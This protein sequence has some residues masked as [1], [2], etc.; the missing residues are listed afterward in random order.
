MANKRVILIIL[1]GW[2][3]AP[4]W[5]GNAVES[6]ETPVM[7]NLWRKFPHTI[8]KAAEEAVGLPI[9]EPGNSEVGHLN[10]GCGQVV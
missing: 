3:Y 7:D 10:I 5:G 8:L 1:D 9:H 2:G 6:A 4:S